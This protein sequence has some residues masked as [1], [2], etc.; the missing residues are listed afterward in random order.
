M[1]M[2]MSGLAACAALALVAGSAQAMQLP[3]VSVGAGSSALVNGDPSG[4]GLSASMSAM[5][6]ADSPWSFGLMVFADDMGTDLAQFRDVNDGSDRGTYEAR[7]RFAYG[8]AWRVDAALPMRGRWSPYASATWGA[9][10]LQDDTRGDVLAA[11]SATGMSLGA[12]VRHAAL[13]RGTLGLS[14]R[15]HRLQRGP[16]NGWLS[17]ELDWQWLWGRQP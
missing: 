10:R 17:A 8:A 12:G 4:G 16:S 13:T 14:A 11:T 5:W 15:W 9:Y 7:H 2:H 3:D 6:D 1:R